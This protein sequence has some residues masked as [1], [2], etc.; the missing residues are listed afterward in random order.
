MP[1][2]ILA[3]MKVFVW[4]LFLAKNRIY[5]SPWHVSLFFLSFLLELRPGWLL[6]LH[7]LF[8]RS[9]LD[10]HTLT[11]PLNVLECCD[12]T[13]EVRTPSSFDFWLILPSCYI[14]LFNVKILVENKEG[15]AK[16][17]A[18]GEQSHKAVILQNTYDF[19]SFTLSHIHTD[20]GHI[21]LN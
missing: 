19:M 13:T 17:S 18:M 21:T 14:Y 12:N 6:P 7:Y 20:S 15:G 2:A 16:N 10:T 5:L 3:F 8:R 4:D 11:I 1:G 9:C